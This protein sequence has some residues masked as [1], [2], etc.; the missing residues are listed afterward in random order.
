MLKSKISAAPA[1]P[2]PYA[3][4]KPD[5]A[6]KQYSPCSSR[7]MK[8][9]VGW[10]SPL[11]TGIRL[12]VLTYA[13]KRYP[14]KRDVQLRFTG[15]ASPCGSSVA[16]DPEDGGR[17]LERIVAIVCA[18]VCGLGPAFDRAGKAAASAAAAGVVF[19][20][21]RADADGAA[22]IQPVVPLVRGTERG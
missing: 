10:L 8:K 3:P 21:E 19:D 1:A 14:A 7:M 6:R 12:Y 17:G 18:H 16:A 2:A 11:K 4:P 20:S 22:G 9:I 13:R 5:E 15:T